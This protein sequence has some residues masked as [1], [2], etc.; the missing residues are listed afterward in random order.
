MG[1]E[2]RNQKKN[3]VGIESTER[4]RKIRKKREKEMDKNKRERERE[5]EKESRFVG[6]KEN[7]I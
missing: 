6:K 7:R 5:G 4:K 2:E 3:E 1:V